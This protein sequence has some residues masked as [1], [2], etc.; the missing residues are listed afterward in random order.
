MALTL[1]MGVF[2]DT[3]VCHTALA[4]NQERML[5]PIHFVVFVVELFAAFKV[6]V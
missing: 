2:A 3:L 5:L 1:N 4:L 6:S